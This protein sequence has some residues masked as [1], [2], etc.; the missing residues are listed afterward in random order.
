MSRERQ[1]KT[2]PD[3]GQNTVVYGLTQRYA[4]ESQRSCK[5]V[6]LHGWGLAQG[7]MRFGL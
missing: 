7:R 1:S 2:K 6:C 5:P 4:R 3:V